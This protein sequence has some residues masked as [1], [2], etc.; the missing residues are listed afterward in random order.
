MKRDETGANSALIAILGTLMVGLAS[1]VVWLLRLKPQAPHE[2]P[3]LQADTTAG[4]ITQSGPDAVVVARPA[5]QPGSQP[6]P[7]GGPQP[8]KA[9]QATGQS[10]GPSR[11]SAGLEPAPAA[12][13]DGQANT[14]WT[15]PTRYLAGVGLVLSILGVIYYSRQTLTL[16]IF[17]ALIAI[18]ARPAMGFLHRRLRF[19]VG[20]SVIVVYLT[21]ALLLF[22]LPLLIVPNII[23]GINSLLTVDWPG[24]VQNITQWLEQ[25]AAQASS[26]PLV[27]G[28]VSSPIQSVADFA[29]G[30][31]SG[32]PQPVA[33][34]VTVESLLSDLG[35]AVGL[36]RSVLGPLVSGVVSFIFLLLIS[37]QMSLA[38]DEVR[39]WIMSAV[40]LRFESEI[41]ALLDRI[42][43][44][45]S[46]FLRGQFALMVVMGV[47]VW[48]MN[49]AL[50]TPQALL[51]GLLGGLLEIIPSLGPTLAAVPAALLALIFGSAHFSGLD[52]V[53]FMLIVIIGYIL[54]NLLENQVLVPQILGDAVSLPPL[55]VL[56]GVTIAGAQAGIAG[57]FLATPIIASGRELFHFVYDKIVEIPEEEPPEEEKPSVRDRVAAFAGRMRLPFRRRA[58]PA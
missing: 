18:L 34:N 52:P 43:L 50:G 38:G 58:E 32:T 16:L 29:G 37:L 40:P 2:K 20:L 49:L 4:G 54:L 5:P 23:Q 25:A 44:I 56:V 14:R 8:S 10:L 1:F 55:I 28:L 24:M 3:A 19:P 26:M 13:E 45:W 47:L 57:I 41:N 6:I 30:L 27:G 17:A 42:T 22:G 36:L 12:P 21:I 48:L 33:S 39:G 11:G 35:Q 53:I 9:S 51:L 15:A 46:S 31:V 7:L